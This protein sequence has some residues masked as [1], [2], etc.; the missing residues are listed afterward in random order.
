[1][2]AALA[3][4]SRG[5]VWNTFVMVGRLSDFLRLVWESAPDLYGALEPLI[6]RQSADDNVIASIYD[7]IVSTDFSKLVL[8]GGRPPVLPS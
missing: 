4:V 6:S 8:S 7:S 5:C 3:L 2:E 1:M